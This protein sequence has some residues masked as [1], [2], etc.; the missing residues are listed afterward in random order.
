MPL[1]QTQQADL[2]VQGGQETF[3]LFQAIES[4][5][6]ILEINT[7]SKAF[8]VGPQ[9]DISKYHLSF[10]DEQGTDRISAIDLAVG[11]PV[12]GRTDAKLATSYPISQL[13]ARIIATPGDLVDNTFLP[14]TFVG[15][16]DG[17]FARPAP[18]ADIIAALAVP[19]GFAA[20]RND[21]IHSFSPLI[22]AGTAPVASYI[23]VPYYGRSFGHVTLT[24]RNSSAGQTYACDVVGVNLSAGATFSAPAGR[25][26]A[27]EVALGSLTA[28]GGGAGTT[29]DL[30]ITAGTHGM[31][32]LLSIRFTQ[33]VL[34]D[35]D[36]TLRILVSDRI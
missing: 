30:I 10:F 3:R 12:I 22:G 19:S 36:A 33:T 26:K 1:P 11:N 5:G 29:D 15:G 35:E 25:S 13:P 4:L 32:D 8:C 18:F 28:V 16:T 7:S 23:I 14:S 6:D 9:S 20:Q 31:F 21:R 27:G 17:V 2:A 24:N 34:L